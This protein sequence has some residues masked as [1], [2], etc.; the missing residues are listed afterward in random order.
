MRTK[1]ARKNRSKSKRSDL[2]RKFQN[3]FGFRPSGRGTMKHEMEQHLVNAKIGELHDTSCARIAE[4]QEII[5]PYAEANRS[6]TWEA[7]PLMRFH[8]LLVSALDE[9][10]DK[11]GCQIVGVT[12][13]AK[14]FGFD[15]KPARFYGYPDPRASIHKEVDGVIAKMRQQQ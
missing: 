11:I 6:D 12:T 10:L 2:A 14:A 4:I 5:K 3:Y 8:Y 13:L 9:D 7:L 15:V 1:A